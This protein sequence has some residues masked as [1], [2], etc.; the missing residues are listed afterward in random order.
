MLVGGYGT[1][2]NC[3]DGICEEWENV[4]SC[5]VDCVECVAE[6]GSVPLI[7]V[8]PEC[9]EGL[10]LVPSSDPNIVGSSGTCENISVVIVCEDKCGD[11]ICQE[12]VCQAESCPC[13]ET[14]STCAE[15]CVEI[16]IVDG[17]D[18]VV[19]DGGSVIS[20]DGGLSYKWVFLI[21]FVLVLLVIIGL[22]IAK[23]V[24]L[25]AVIAAVVFLLWFFV[26]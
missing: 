21:I 17:G 4:C 15:D 11:G 19:G 10:M 3:G 23:W 16:E 13:V 22:K 9:C 7:A 14:V 24:A 1:C 2:S 8:P 5:E 25:A 26:L 6:G 18:S 12:V 20:D